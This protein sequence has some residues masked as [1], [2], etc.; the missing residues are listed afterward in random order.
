M[1]HYI[2]QYY[3]LIENFITYL[4]YLHFC[5]FVYTLFMHGLFVYSFLQSMEFAKLGNCFKY[6]FTNSF[7][8]TGQLSSFEMYAISFSLSLFSLLR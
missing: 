7:F 6:L 8:F 4:Q 1:V 2:V 5:G 3:M